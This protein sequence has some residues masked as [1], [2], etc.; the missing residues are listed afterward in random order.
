MIPITLELNEIENGLSLPY[1]IHITVDIGKN[2]DLNKFKEICY[3]MNVKPILLELEISELEEL[4]DVMTSSKHIGNNR[5]A[6]EECLKIQNLLENNNF[7][8]IRT[9]IETV[10]WH[11]LAMMC[12]NGYIIENNLYFESH[13]AILVNL[14]EKVKLSE[15][16]NII[17]NKNVLTGKLKLSKNPFKKINEDGRF[18]FMMTYRSYKNSYNYFSEEL[19][20]IKNELK[21]NNFKYQKIEVEFA[22]YDSNINHDFKWL[23]S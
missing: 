4:Q 11:P 16:V 2:F 17:N 5:S 20:I 12:V 14:D 18:I 10:P 19:E 22:I 21:D 7:K 1:E 15:L 13:I 9:K 3:E 8:V 6:Y 23:N